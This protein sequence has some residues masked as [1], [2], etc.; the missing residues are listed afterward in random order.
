MDKSE[1]QHFVV[2]LNCD[3]MNTPFKYLGLLVG[4]CHKRSA[5]WADVLE[6]MKSILGSWKGRFL[7]LARIVCLIKFVLSSIPL[8]YVSLFKF[9]SLVLKEIVKL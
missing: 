6:R 2:L 9:P 1:I 8:F 5:F 7:S 3:V 4:G